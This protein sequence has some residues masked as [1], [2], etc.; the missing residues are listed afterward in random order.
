MMA[1]SSLTL[2]ATSALR[3]NTRRL[4]HDRMSN[5]YAVLARVQQG[6][7]RHSLFLLV[8]ILAVTQSALEL[9]VAGVAAV[10]AAG[11]AV[12]AVGGVVDTALVSVAEAEEEDMIAIIT[13]TAASLSDLLT[14]R[15]LIDMMPT[16]G[17]SISTMGSTVDSSGTTMEAPSRTM[18]EAAIKAG[19]PTVINVVVDSLMI[20]TT[21][22]EAVVAMAGTTDRATINTEARK[23]NN[24]MIGLDQAITSTISRHMEEDTIIRMIATTINERVTTRPTYDR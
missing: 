18:T 15:V 13:T 23:I 9:G 16:K 5:R 3:P 20:T 12:E 2:K 14:G 1:D 17:S 19:T 11:E 4:M 24:G 10:E 7:K 21:L 8:P 22:Q 6:R